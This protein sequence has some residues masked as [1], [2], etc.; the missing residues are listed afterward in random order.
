MLMQFDPLR[1]FDRLAGQLAAGARWPRPCPMDAYRRV[2]R[3]RGFL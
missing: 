2:E 1:E 3:V